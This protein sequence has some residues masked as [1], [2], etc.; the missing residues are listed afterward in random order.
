[1]KAAAL[2]ALAALL[3]GGAARAVDLRAKSTSSSK[4]F[5]VYCSDFALR[6][7]ITGFVED[8]KRDVLDLL[9]ERDR[10]RIPIVVTLEAAADPAAVKTPVSLRLSQT[11]AGPTI[12]LGVTIG[13]DPAVVHLQKQIIRAVLLDYLYRDHPPEGGQSYAEAPWWFIAGAIE[14]FRQRDAGIDA[15]F[16]RRLIETNKLPS[17]TDFLPGHG[18]ELG[19][20]AAAF[21]NACAFALLE[22]LLEQPESKSRL[23]QFL[24]NWPDA[25]GDV[26][27]ALGQAFPALGPDPASLQKWW[28]L[29]LARF[30][31]SDRYRGLSAEDTDHE[32]QTLLKFEV[33]ADKAGRTKSFAIGQFKEFTRLRGARTAAAAQQKAVIALSTK[34][35]ILLRPVLADYE[36]V[37][38]LLARGKTRGIAERIHHAETY[39]TAVLLRKNDITDYLNWF[40]ATQLGTRSGAFDSYL[41]AARAAESESPHTAT[42]AAISAYLDLFED[43]L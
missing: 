40:E 37:F 23:A 43:E 34:A 11:P 42:S 22:L 17:V 15:E 8:V 28:T 9:G 38:A 29:N 19:G 18:Q 24:R 14:K 5:T 4:Q 32:L 20:S 31:A 30:A 26:V 25:Q 2:L 16:F 21:D 1:V 6:G 3:G 33:A 41:R 39:R 7:R 27:A 35:N 12:Q 13:D 10:W 36:Q